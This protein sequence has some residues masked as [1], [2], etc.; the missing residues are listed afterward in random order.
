MYYESDSDMLCLA[1]VMIESPI[2]GVYSDIS[3]CAL[4]E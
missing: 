2:Y 4:I 3:D 1:L